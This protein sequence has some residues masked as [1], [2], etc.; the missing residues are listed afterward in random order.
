MKLKSALLVI[1]LSGFA[2]LLACQTAPQQTVAPQGDNVRIVKLTVP[3]AMQDD[4]A[5]RVRRILLTL[6][7][8]THVSTAPRVGQVDVTYDQ[9]KVKVEEMEAVLKEKGFPVQSKYFVK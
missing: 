5:N 2:L 4:I 8:V 9:T 7:G 3:E 1:L 6:D